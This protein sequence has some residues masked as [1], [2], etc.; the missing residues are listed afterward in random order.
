M[1]QG[2]PQDKNSKNHK[3]SIMIYV[4]GEDQFDYLNGALDD[5]IILSKKRNLFFKSRFQIIAHMTEEYLKST[6]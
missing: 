2:A 6:R 5:A 4:S 3:R 1:R